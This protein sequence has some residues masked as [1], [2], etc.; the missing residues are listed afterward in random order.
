MQFLNTSKRK[1]IFISKQEE[2]DENVLSRIQPIKVRWTSFYNA[3]DRILFKYTS[4]VKSL[5]EIYNEDK[6]PAGKGFEL[7]LREFKTIKI[8]TILWD[9]F[10]ILNPLEIY[11]QKHRISINTAIKVIGFTSEK[12]KLSFSDEFE[13]ATRIFTEEFIACTKYKDMVLTE[14]PEISTDQILQTLRKLPKPIKI[15]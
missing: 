3:I 6:D 7:F 12:I 10:S 15:I 14:V 13:C 8:L 11:L 2:T 9:L 4:I 1:E 5:K